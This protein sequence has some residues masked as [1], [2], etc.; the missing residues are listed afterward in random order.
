MEQREGKRGYRTT[1]SLFIFWGILETHSV[2]AASACVVGNNYI[3]FL[4]QYVSKCLT[5][6]TTLCAYLY[7]PLSLTHTHTLSLSLSLCLS[8]TTDGRKTSFPQ[9]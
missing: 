8:V 5:S 3:T 6:S 2:P 4:R 7:L 1:A 9:N